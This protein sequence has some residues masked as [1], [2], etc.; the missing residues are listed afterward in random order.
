MN[1]S[2]GLTWSASAFAVSIAG[3]GI[4]CS[5]SN[6]TTGGA[7]GAG[8]IVL[9]GAAGAAPGGGGATASHEM[10]ETGGAVMPV[11][12]IPLTPTGG[13]KGPP[14]MAGA[15]V[16][17]MDPGTGL[18]IQGAVFSF[19][20]PTSLV[21]MM[22]D[23]TTDGKACI[24]GTAAK[25]DQLSPRCMPPI[26]PATD[27]IGVFFGAFVAVNLNQPNDP[28]TN[29]GSA[30]L[31][32]DATKLQGFSFEIT[33]GAATGLAGVPPPTNLRFNVENANGEFCTP[34]LKPI[35]A[36]ANTVLFSELLANCSLISTMPANPTAEMAKSDLRRISWQVVTWD[37]RPVPFD[38]CVSNIVAI[39]L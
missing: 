32:F 8:N 13:N 28:L 23:F 21:G 9:A 24:M 34:T 6:S 7:A 11:T 38:F 29:T 25:V 33:G 3:V 14:Q 27:C 31:P 4:G 16:D 20:D 15:F 19:A 39:P 17:A 30:P 5:S 10:P 22:A 37:K 1:L 26:P 18:H 12:G 2:I 36:G 35:R